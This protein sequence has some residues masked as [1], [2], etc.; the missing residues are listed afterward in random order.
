MLVECIPCDGRM[1]GRQKEVVIMVIVLQVLL[2]NVCINIYAH[3]FMH[4]G[5]TENSDL[6]KY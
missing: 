3:M 2:V 1:N 6:L 5:E 4:I